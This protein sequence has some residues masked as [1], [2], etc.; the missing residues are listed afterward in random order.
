MEDVMS[1]VKQYI[2][3]NF[4]VAKRKKVQYDDVLLESG[5]VDSLGVMEIVNYLVARFEIEI[6][7]DDL[8]PENFRTVRSISEFVKLKRNGNGNV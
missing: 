5:I 3:S 4:P 8:V 1:E 2:V 6:D 7:E